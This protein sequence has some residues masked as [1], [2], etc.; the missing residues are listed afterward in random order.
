MAAGVAR[1]FFTLFYSFSIVFM[2]AGV[3]RGVPPRGRADLRRLVCRG[4][5]APGAGGGACGGKRGGGREVARSNVMRTGLPGAR[6]SARCSPTYARGRVPGAR[7][8]TCVVSLHSPLTC[9]SFFFLAIPPVRR[10]RGAPVVRN[11]RRGATARRGALPTQHSA[12]RP[13][14]G[15]RWARAHHQGG[16]ALRVSGRPCS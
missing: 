5:G 3:A 15:G 14:G 11:I 2:A 10:A 9:V 13:R 4:R 12:R 6:R 16:A 8:L 1:G 7:R